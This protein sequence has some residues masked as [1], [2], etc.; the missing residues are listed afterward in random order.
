MLDTDRPASSTAWRATSQPT[1]SS[2]GEM[3]PTLSTPSSA[4]NTRS[5]SNDC[6]MEQIALTDRRGCIA[7]RAVRADRPRRTSVSLP[8]GQLRCEQ[9]LHAAELDGDVPVMVLHPPAV[10]R[11]HQAGRLYAE[12][13]V[14]LALPRTDA[15]VHGAHAH[16]H[17]GLVA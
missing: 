10:G 5:S 8:G 1:A 9:V 12:A 7:Q 3:R 11:P 13:L 16:H 2:F 15:V 4:H 17:L 14:E 6:F